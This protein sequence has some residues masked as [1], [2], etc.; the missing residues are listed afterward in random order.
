MTYILDHF[1]D[2]IRQSGFR[3]LPDDSIIQRDGRVVG[4]FATLDRAGLSGF[5]RN[6]A[7]LYLPYGFLSRVVYDEK[8]A[9]LGCR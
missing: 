6:L 9:R 2:R 4:R 1:N 5:V 7:R 8:R 3:I